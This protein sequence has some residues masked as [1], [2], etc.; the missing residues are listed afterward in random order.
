MIIKFLRVCIMFMG[1]NLL[2]CA[3]ELVMKQQEF[4]Q[5]DEKKA[6][7][8]LK[9]MLNKSSLIATQDTHTEDAKNK[10]ATIMT[11]AFSIPHIAKFSLGLDF[12]EYS[13]ENFKKFK[14]TLSN[15]LLKIY[16]T[17]E[18]IDVFASINIEDDDINA[19]PKLSQRKNRLTYNAV[20][21][22]K[23]GPVNTQFVIIKVKSDD[24]K[25]FDIVVEGIGLLSN[26]RSQASVLK[27]LSKKA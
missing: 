5:E 3:Q 20:F 6:F 15:Y 19:I 24:Y 2:L 13:A 21:K 11:N 17:Q 1:M 7:I 8:F 12:K 14:N 10:F 23:K 25:I 26:L 22:S 16:A 4:N 27:D 18:K 9:N